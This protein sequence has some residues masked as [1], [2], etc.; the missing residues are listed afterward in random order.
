M[1]APTLYL[2]HVPGAQGDNNLVGQRGV[3]QIPD[4]E[5]PALLVSFFYAKGFIENRERFAVREWVMDS[6]AHSAYRSGKTIDLSA[7]I[8]A[9]RLLLDR[10]PTL[11]EVFG[12]DVIGDWK[13]G[14][15]N[16]EAMWKAGIPAVPTYHFGE[17]WEVLRDY[18]ADFPWKIAI[19]GAA[20]VK[21]PIKLKQAGQIFA[22]AWPMR[23]HGF[24]FGTRKAAMAL[25]WHSTDATNWEVGPCQFGSW[26]SLPGVNQRGSAQN[27]RAE[28]EYYMNAEREAC[29]RWRR[30]MEML[31]R[32]RPAW[33][34]RRMP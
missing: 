24:A 22:R 5:R 14:R 20:G 10:D 29:S 11:V 28:I 34:I 4:A 13:A 33:P 3:A 17:P 2:A 25:P 26:K 27:L 30:E 19:G 1:T 16:I 9:C 15:A 23:I 8:D 18:I 6:G 7:Y 21:G 31:E 32:E 12:L